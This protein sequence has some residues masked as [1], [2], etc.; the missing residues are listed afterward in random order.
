[1]TA[2]LAETPMAD[3]LA[4][5]VDTPAHGTDRT[6]MGLPALVAAVLG[7]PNGQPKVS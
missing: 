4:G 6:P 2:R 1:M 3:D 5:D 7:A